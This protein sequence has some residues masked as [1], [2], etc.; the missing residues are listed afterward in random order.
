MPKTASGYV[1]DL[2]EVAVTL[3]AAN[4]AA[5]AAFTTAEE[6]IADG[7]VRMFER[8]NAPSKAVARTNV[9]GDSTPIVF[10]SNRVQEEELWRLL[11]VD[12][13][14]E[15]L[16][17]EW[18]TDS[19]SMVEIFRELLDNN[20]DPGTLQ[21]TPAG[22]ATGDIEYTLTTPRLLSVGVPKIDAD[23]IDLEEVEILLASEGHTVAAHA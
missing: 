12:D 21:G 18:G 3:S 9:T 8:T 13:Y 5:V 17:G 20:Q 1:S 11:L 2:G 15:G 23:S 4:V 10:R 14:S 22:G 6:I 7:T 16:T 19:L